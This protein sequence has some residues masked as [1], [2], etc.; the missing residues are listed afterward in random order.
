MRNTLLFMIICLLATGCV[1][2]PKPQPELRWREIPEGYL[3]PCVLPPMPEDTAD[4][5]DA[6][7]QA[8]QCG[9]IGNKDKERIKSLPGDE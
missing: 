1:T 5:S 2:R 6:F 8:Y 4:L 7:V 3:Q 9:E